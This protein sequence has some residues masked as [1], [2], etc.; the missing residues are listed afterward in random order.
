MP[1]VSTPPISRPLP[2]RLQAWLWTGPLGHLYGG[3]ADLMLLLG[4]IA[5]ARAR[6]VIGRPAKGR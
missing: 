5:A 3:V 4:R 6:S 1:G 2:E